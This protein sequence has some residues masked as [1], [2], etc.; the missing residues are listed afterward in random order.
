MKKF[1]SHMVVTWLALIFVLCSTAVVADSEVADPE[2]WYMESYG[3]LW[4]VDPYNKI[5]EVLSH[6]HSEIIDHNDGGVLNQQSTA[7]W[8]SG[9][10]ELWKEDGWTTSELTD[11]QVDRISESVT[12]F[13]SR[14]LDHYKDA[15]D[16]YVCGWYF[17][18][19]IDGHWKFTQ[20]ATI[21]CA[22]LAE[23]SS[24]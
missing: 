16:E 18:E 20:Y 23:D 19:L 21:D 3:P 24:S 4:N 2:K 8:I 17:A 11:L 7:A 9:S 13:K 5:N 10:F 15:E 22:T 1:R 6:Y 12:S 14:W